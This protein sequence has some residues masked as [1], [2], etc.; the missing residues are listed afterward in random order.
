MSTKNGWSKASGRVN[1]LSISKAPTIYGS[2]SIPAAGPVVLKY[3]T[4]DKS[5]AP[6]KGA[7][8]KTIEYAIVGAAFFALFAYLMHR[9]VAS[10]DRCPRLHS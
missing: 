7:A 4:T 9:A 10:T 5:F 3:H 6:G 8:A 2:T 1:V